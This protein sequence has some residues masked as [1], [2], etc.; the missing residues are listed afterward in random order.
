M[1]FSCSLAV[2][3]KRGRNVVPPSVSELAQDEED[4]LQ[5]H[6][7][8]LRAD[9]RKEDTPR[10]RFRPDSALLEEFHSLLTAGVSQF[11]EVSSVLV[12]ALARAMM[13][14]SNAKDCVVAILTSGSS[15][16]VQHV[17]LLKLDA[18]IEAARLEQLRDGIRLRVFRDLLPRPGDLQKGLSWPD[19]RTGVSDIVVKDRNFG[20]TA[21]Y[22]QNAF[23]VDA[24][25]SATDTERVFI[26]A[27]A[28]SL[29]ASD[30]AE[31][32]TLIGDGGLADQVSLRVRERFPEFQIEARELGAGGALAG[33]IRPLSSRVQRKVFRA[34]GME[35]RVPVDRL[36]DVYTVRSGDRYE[37][38]IETASPLTPLR[39]SKGT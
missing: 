11:E 30:V 10:G 29:P 16:E 8:S 19:P 34:D 28:D 36:A 25:P 4:F 37:T 18:E 2:I 17:S 27:L 33:R 21:L 23:G 22:F 14:A 1:I 24:S 32:I 20:Q 38:R 6:V 12:D 15:A 7:N 39:D 5:R 31:A 9:A 3:T 13:G 35:L 26:N